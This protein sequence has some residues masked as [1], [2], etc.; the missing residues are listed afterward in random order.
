MF[1]HVIGI[2]GYKRLSK[3]RD[4]NGVTSRRHG[5]SGRV[6]HTAYNVSNQTHVIFINDFATEDWTSHGNGE[7]CQVVALLYEYYTMPKP[8]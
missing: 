7:Y 5:R 2:K 8:N 6:T 3:H 4:E 1:A